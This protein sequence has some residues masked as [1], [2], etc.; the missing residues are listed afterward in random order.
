MLLITHWVA[1]LF[2]LVVY[3]QPDPSAAFKYDG[4]LLTRPLY[5]QYVFSAVWSIVSL[6][7]YLNSDPKNDI[8]YFFYTVVSLFGVMTYVAIIGTVASLLNNLDQSEEYFRQKMNTI[9]DLMQFRN[10]PLDMQN[11]I[12]EYYLYLWSSR[13]GLDESEVTS[14]LP[15]YLRMEIAMFLNKEV[16]AKVPLFQV[17]NTHFISAVVTRMKPR[18]ALP[19]AYIIRKGEVGKEM[20]FLA[21]GQVEVVGDEDQVFATLPEGSHFGEVALL[22]SGKRTANVRAKAYCDLFV[23][24]KEDFHAVLHEFPEESKTVQEEAGRRYAAAAQAAQQA[25]RAREEAERRRQTLDVK[26]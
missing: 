26:E 5:A 1:C 8:E 25:Q 17:A 11:R 21:R 4:D 9:N 16:I 13:K 10:L 12:R 2:Y 7:G 20:F 14:D 22:F 24:T 23:L 15:Q 18:V 6:T 19:G 3:L